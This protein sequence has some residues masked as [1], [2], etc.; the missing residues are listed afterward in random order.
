MW[1]NYTGCIISSRKPV[2]GLVTCQCDL[3]S[4]IDKLYTI[5]ITLRSSFPVV[6]ILWWWW[7]CDSMWTGR[8]SKRWSWERIPL[9]Q[10]NSQERGI[11]LLV[12]ACV[13]VS[14]NLD[15]HVPQSENLPHVVKM[16]KQLPTSSFFNL[17]H[18]HACM[19]LWVCM[20]ARDWVCVC[21]IFCSILNLFFQIDLFREEYVKSFQG[22]LVGYAESQI[23]HSKRTRE[24]LTRIRDQLLDV[25]IE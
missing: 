9:N 4:I 1:P 10:W 2:L 21:F 14:R 20:C 12:A 8:G 3:Y 13:N 23:S 25:T 5:S 22:N 7:S 6:G 15:M 16:T 24:N 19:S 18:S 11:M 17:L